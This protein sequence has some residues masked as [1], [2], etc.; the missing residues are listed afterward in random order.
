MQKLFVRLNLIL[1]LL[2]E[3]VSA[4]PDEVQYLYQD[5]PWH[6]MRGLRNQLVHAYFSIAPKILWDTIR[7]SNY[8]FLIA[9]NY[10]QTF[11]VYAFSTRSYLI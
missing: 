5:V 10:P 6:L 2:T 9:A 1:S 3:A 7:R 8:F 11:F 4:I